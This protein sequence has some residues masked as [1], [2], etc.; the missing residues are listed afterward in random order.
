MIITDDDF[1]FLRKNHF[2]SENLTIYLKS[3]IN[4][5]EIPFDYNKVIDLRYRIKKKY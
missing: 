1:K 3:L 5:E 4:E 2:L